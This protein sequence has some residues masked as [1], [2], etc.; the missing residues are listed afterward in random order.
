MFAVVA[1]VYGRNSELAEQA[2]VDSEPSEVGSATWTPIA[3]HAGYE[4][5]VIDGRIAVRNKGKVLRSVPSRVKE[6]SEVL[7]LGRLLD[8]LEV[9]RR[10]CRADIEAWVGRSARIPEAVLLGIW[11]DSAWSELLRDLVVVAEDGTNGLLRGVD[12]ESG[13]GI[14]TLD[15]ESVWASSPHWNIPHPVLI[16]D[17]PDY[18]ELASQL[19]IE[20][21]IAQLFRETY[22]RDAA[23]HPDTSTQID[24]YSDARFEEL[25]FA[26][27]RSGSGGYA[28]R[29]GYA[30]LTVR[31][32][33]RDLQARFWIGSDAPDSE[34]WTGDLCWVDEKERVLALADV[35]PVAYSEGVRMAAYIYAGRTISEENG[36]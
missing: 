14:V 29:G 26:T 22:I 25:R 32:R 24:D 2:L 28:V 27:G 21:Q 33:S 36:R 15:G 3:G 11:S 17:L 9:H 20:Q 31:E 30:C 12:P 35:G 5:T 8:W 7:D 10:E 19:N 4:C 18:R 6:S 34:T 16:E 13:I 1:F 23:V